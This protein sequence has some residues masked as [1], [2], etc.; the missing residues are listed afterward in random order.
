MPL[1]P[2]SEKQAGILWF[3]LTGIAMLLLAWLLFKLL[4]LLTTFIALLS[5]VLL[6]L[7]IAAIIACLLDPVV[8]ALGR[9]KIPRTR[10]IILV[11]FIAA[12]LV[13]LL[14][15][16]AL[17]RLFLEIQSF[18]SNLPQYTDRLLALRFTW[19]EGMTLRQY[20]AHEWNADLGVKAKEGLSQAMPLLTTWLFAAWSYA[21]SWLGFIA[22]LA[23]VPV[24]AFYFLD[25]REGIRD[26]WTDY[27]PL[28]DGHVK[29]ELVFILRSINDCLIVFFR[30][31]ILVAACVGTLLGIGFSLVGLKYALLLGV[32]AGLLT[33]IPYLGVMLSLGPVVLLAYLQFGDIAHPALILGV[34]ILVQMAEGFVITPKIIGD[35]IGLHPMTIIIG[36]M[37]GTTLL[38]GVVG[39]ILA[40]PIT[41]VLRTLMFRYVWIKRRASAPSSHSSP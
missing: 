36:V 12:M 2:P 24:Y 32:V 3:C 19:T 33:I 16:V 34:F 22:G 5:P 41:A 35:R 39:G 40:I 18:I 21:S 4:G 7:A 28:Q 20:V 23:L 17:P 26:H 38:G 29:D 8:D 1:P 14:L 9:L 6:P 25:E 37:V 30:G 27:L 10:A 15:S 13:A 11:F 31:Q